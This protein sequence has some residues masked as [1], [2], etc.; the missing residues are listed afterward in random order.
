MSDTF[1]SEDAALEEVRLAVQEFG[2]QAALSWALGSKQAR[3]GLRS[4]AAGRELIDR[5]FAI[6]A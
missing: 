1:P 3:G 5:A 2:E 4:I 6:P